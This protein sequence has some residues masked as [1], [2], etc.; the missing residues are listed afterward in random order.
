MA[1][2]GRAVASDHRP[3]VGFSR[4]SLSPELLAWLL[5][6]D[7]FQ[8]DEE[9]LLEKYQSCLKCI[10]YP[11]IPE[12]HYIEGYFHGLE[13]SQSFQS[14]NPRTGHG[15]AKPAAPT[16]L[17]AF[18]TTFRQQNHNWLQ[19]LSE[20]EDTPTDWKSLVQQNRCFSDVALQV[21]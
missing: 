10:D 2:Y 5:E 13:T 1:F 4:Y 15:F 14:L 19:P 8:C 20:L 9:R 12:H 17:R 6:A 11:H 7:V 21:K 18:L 16:R 3:E